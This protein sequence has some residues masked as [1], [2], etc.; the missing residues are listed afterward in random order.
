MPQ[1][2]VSQAL[3]DHWL[4]TGQAYLDGELLRLPPQPGGPSAHLDAAVLF[5]RTEGASGDPHQLVGT[6][7][8][9]ADLAAMGAEHFDTSV[10][11]ADQAYQV[12]PGYLAV[13][14]GQGGIAAL[15]DPSAWS[16]LCATLAAMTP[17]T[18]S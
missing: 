16:R 1:I 10:V 12:K 11:L 3:L 7:R 5:E 6:V 15:F 2:Y 14:V 4:A 17:P 9:A 13:F 18:S 8:S